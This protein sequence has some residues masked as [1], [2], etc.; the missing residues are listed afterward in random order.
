MFEIFAYIA[1]LIP[2]IIP[3]FIDGIYGSGRGHRLINSIVVAFVITTFSYL[4]LA[5]IYGYYDIEFPIP[6]FVVKQQ[7]IVS[8]LLLSQEYSLLENWREIAWTSLIA[9]IYLVIWL[10]IVRLELMERVLQSLRLTD[11]SSALD[12]WSK[13]SKIAF[14]RKLFVQ[15]IDNKNK[16][17]YTGWIDGYSS[18]DDF[19]ELFLL[20]VEIHD[21]DFKLVAKAPKVYIG[22]PNDSV[23]ILYLNNERR[24]Q[25]ASSNQKSKSV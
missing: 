8:S 16:R 9:L 24:I 3:A 10:P 19:R 2:G 25:N 11:Y 4:T 12:I 14:K 6:L 1:L 18:Y 13:V 21:F 23:T 22:L 15:V 5:G 20:F 17:Y 7:S